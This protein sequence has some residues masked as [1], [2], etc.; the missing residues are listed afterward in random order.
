MD[1]ELSYD[2]LRTDFENIVFDLQGITTSEKL[3]RVER[4]YCD[5]SIVYTPEAQWARFEYYQMYPKQEP[6]SSNCHNRDATWSGST[7]ST[8]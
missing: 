2:W 4:K 8:W 6:S 3:Y 1:P 5:M 7:G